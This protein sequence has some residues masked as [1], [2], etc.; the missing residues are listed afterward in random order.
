[1]FK[2]YVHICSRLFT[3][4]CKCR[5]VSDMTICYICTKRDTVRVNFGSIMGIL[6]LEVAQSEQVCVSAAA[7]RRLLIIVHL[8][9][10]GA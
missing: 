1:M 7:I 8:G 5:L 9:H 4:H 2:Y 6:L 10:V 3:Y